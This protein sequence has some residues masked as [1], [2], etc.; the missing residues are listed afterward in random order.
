MGGYVSSLRTV[1]VVVAC[2]ILGS[3]LSKFGTAKVAVLSAALMTASWIAFALAP[4]Y[5]WLLL[6]VIPLGFGSGALNSGINNFIA[7]HYRPRHLD[8]L[9]SC[10]G[11]G[12]ISAPLLM[13]TLIKRPG[14]WRMAC[15][16]IA[17]LQFLITMVLLFNSRLWGAVG[18]KQTQ[19]DQQPP[20]DFR[21]RNADLHPIR[22]KGMVWAAAAFFLYTAIEVIVSMWLSS[23]LIHTRGVDEAF[24]SRAVSVFFVGLTAVR[25]LSAFTNLRIRATW[26]VRISVAC[27]VTGSVLLLL[28][29][30]VSAAWPTAF[31]IGFGCGPIFATL[32][33]LSPLRFGHTGKVNPIGFQMS[34]SFLGGSVFPPLIG[35]L[36]AQIDFS[37]M[38]VSLI[39]LTILLLL[40]NEQCDRSLR[41]H[42]TY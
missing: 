19:N 5:I 12:A 22:M 37:V 32:V 28:L 17:V 15:L 18:S 21:A 38:P 13:S 7:V 24:G 3:L 35:G 40:T 6:S 42:I 8:W 27:I 29:N 31:L 26:T 30:S 25:L 1:G 9:H 20:D 33:S 4:S 34:A 23:F 41:P 2:Y 16:I 10:F 14:G 36:F 11:I 39:I